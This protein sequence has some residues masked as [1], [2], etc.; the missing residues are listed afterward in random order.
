MT[1]GTNSVEALIDHEALVASRYRWWGVYLVREKRRLQGI[2]ETVQAEAAQAIVRLEAGQSDPQGDLP[3]NI[4]SPD[5]LLTRVDSEIELND[6]AEALD[7]AST[8][9]TQSVVD[10]NLKRR[11]ARHSAFLRDQPADEGEDY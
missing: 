5:A 4:E 3:D 7:T 1:V 6:A 8:E 11:L 2:A 9:D 10:E